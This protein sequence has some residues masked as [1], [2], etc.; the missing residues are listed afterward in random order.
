M[1]LS[2]VFG[3]LLLSADEAL[4]SCGDYVFV[5]NPL[6]QSEMEQRT[7]VNDGRVQPLAG[8]NERKNASPIAPPPCHGPLCQGS[9][10]PAAVPP[11]VPPATTSGKDLAAVTTSLQPALREFATRVSETTP[12]ALAGYP[13]TIEHP[14]RG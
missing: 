14:P 7:T 10:P 3:W 11:V 5:G 13:Q 8:R 12:A 2:V 9:K 6:H 4:G 1:A